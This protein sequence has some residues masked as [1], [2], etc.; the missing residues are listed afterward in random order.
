ML[1]INSSE[2]SVLLG[3]AETAEGATGL[4]QPELAPSTSV[5]SWQRGGLE[6]SG[7]REWDRRGSGH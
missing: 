1:A 7:V 3:C 6:T 4:A 5:G 2:A